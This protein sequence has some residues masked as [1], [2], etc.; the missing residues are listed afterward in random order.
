MSLFGSG[1]GRR[2]GNVLGVVDILK[3]RARELGGIDILKD[4]AHVLGVVELANILL[5]S[6][7]CMTAW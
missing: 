6:N 3:D 2:D 4:R 1:S 5:Y 7:F